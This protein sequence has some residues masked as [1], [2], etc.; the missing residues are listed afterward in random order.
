VLLELVNRPPQVYREDPAAFQA[1]AAVAASLAA[2]TDAAAAGQSAPNKTAAAA[3][4]AQAAV[5]VIGAG[6]RLQQM[7]TIKPGSDLQSASTT[8]SGSLSA[9]SASCSI[10][11]A[12]AAALSSEEDW[13]LPWELDPMRLLVEAL[14]RQ[15]VK[16]QAA[17]L[18]NSM[19]ML[20]AGA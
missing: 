9:D 13:S 19:A 3:A 14:C 12:A 5:G 6:E 15:G 18:H 11:A 16:F 1:A 20:E 4:A 10:E 17:L 2:E 8:T 7:A